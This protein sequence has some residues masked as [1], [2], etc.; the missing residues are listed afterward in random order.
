MPSTIVANDGDPTS[1]FRS[2]R[3]SRSQL[4]GLRLTVLIR[5]NLDSPRGPHR[6]PPS[7]PIGGLQAVIS[8]FSSHMSTDVRVPGVSAEPIALNAWP[9]TPMSSGV[10]KYCSTTAV[11]WSSS[12][13]DPEARRGNPLWRSVRLLDAREQLLQPLGVHPREPD[14]ANVHELLLWIR[15]TRPQPPTLTRPP[16]AVRISVETAA[17]GRWE[18]R[19]TCSENVRETWAQN[20][21]GTPALSPMQ[22]RCRRCRSGRP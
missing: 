6:M 19:R 1:P 16:A 14:N 12:K 5:E 4:L 10:S 8:S 21:S 18:Q 2:R 13:K 15:L 22:P 3:Q 7:G 9:P 11:P 20:P 17:R